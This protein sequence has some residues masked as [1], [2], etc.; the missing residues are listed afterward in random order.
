MCTLIGVNMGKRKLRL[1]VCKDYER[2]KYC[3]RKPSLIVRKEHWLKRSAAKA[4]MPQEQ[5]KVTIPISF[6]LDLPVIDSEILFER[7]R[8]LN[9][10]PSG[11]CLEDQT[12]HAAVVI[13]SKKFPF[14]A[15][16]ITVTSNGSWTVC[17]NT[18]PI[19]HSL[20]LAEKITTLAMF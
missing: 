14:C 1:S 20:P 18:T 16:E 4:I 13:I 10:L 7:V 17:V 12:D 19:D 9:A 3:S 5:F 6:Y 8:K 11:W 15:L 2:K